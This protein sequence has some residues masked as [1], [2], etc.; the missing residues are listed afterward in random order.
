MS[1]TFKINTYL[2]QRNI[3]VLLR[4]QLIRDI[5]RKRVSK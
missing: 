4:Q 3:I 5:T 1:I 2:Q